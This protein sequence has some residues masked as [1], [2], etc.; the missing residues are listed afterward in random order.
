MSKMGN[1]VL[2]VDGLTDPSNTLSAYAS[3]RENGATQVM[4]INKTS[5]P[6]IETV[7][8]KGFDPRG[9]SVS[10]YQ[11]T[12][13]A[14]GIW[15][16]SVKYNGVTSP[17]ATNAKGLP[18]PH[19]SK[20]TSSTYTIT[21]PAYSMTMLDF[22]TGQK[23]LA[24]DVRIAAPGDTGVF[25]ANTPLALSA[26]AI[27]KSGS[28]KSVQFYQGS[29]LIGAATAG[30]NNLFSF[31]WAN[32]AAGTYVISAKAIAANG[33]ASWSAPVTITLKASGA[34][35]TVPTVPTTVIQAENFDTGG[36]GIA[37]HKI[38][39]VNGSAYRPGD[40]VNIETTTDTGGGYDV[41]ASQRGEF[42]QYTVNVAKAGT[43]TMT[44][45]YSATSA[46]GAFHLA[47]N[48]KAATKPLVIPPTV[49]PQAW[50]NLIVPNVSLSA[51]KNVLR[52]IMDANGSNGSI[53]N[54]NWFSFA[55][56][57]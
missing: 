14:G 52:L 18:A 51:G 12:G 55:F 44:I 37:Y 39:P 26:E 6:R 36:E 54:F 47:V 42:L 8:F 49:G 17:D 5:S 10:E 1:Q 45:R 3:R 16:S 21:V 25:P 11:L 19:T 34:Y 31:N 15:D 23:A 46:G 33:L 4:F 7:S 40:G 27:A 57:H 35:K 2:A 53:A 50:L 43:Y 56:V 20:V 24:P 32:P 22:L 28:V 13:S 41:T 48:G 30:S 9:K 38:S 29:T